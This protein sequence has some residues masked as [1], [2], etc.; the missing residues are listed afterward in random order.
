MEEIEITIENIYLKDASFEAPYG[1]AN[2]TTTWKPHVDVEMN[3][4]STKLKGEKGV[5]YE[6]VLRVTIT[7]KQKNDVFFLVEVQQA[8]IFGVRG[9]NEEQVQEIIYAQ[10][11]NALFPFA[12]E[13][14]S[15]LVTRG[16]FPQLLLKPMNFENIYRQKSEAMIEQES[17]K[18]TH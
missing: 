8:G 12:R 18:V 15:N 3:T 6:V 14:I 7:A 13:S 11:P 2:L 5:L 4:K 16:G 17:I 1:P 9:G 10:C